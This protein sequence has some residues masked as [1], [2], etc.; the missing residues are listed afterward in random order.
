MCDEAR[1]AFFTKKKER[2]SGNQIR[3]SKK[4]RVHVRLPNIELD[5]EDQSRVIVVKYIVAT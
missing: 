2:N 4:S 3:D 1:W 5:K